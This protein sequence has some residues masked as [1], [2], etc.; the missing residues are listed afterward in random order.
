MTQHGARP[1]CVPRIG[2]PASI[3]HRA[4]D[5][6]LYSLNEMGDE[7]DDE[8]FVELDLEKT[9]TWTGNAV[10]IQAGGE[11][12]LPPSCASE[13]PR[14]PIRGGGRL[15]HRVL[16]H[17]PGRSRGRLEHGALPNA[18]NSFLFIRNLALLLT[19]MPLFSHHSSS[20]RCAWPT[21]RAARHR[22]DG[23]VRAALV[24]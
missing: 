6:Q 2:A 8:E 14:N 5:T 17:V 16:A 10:S 20:S 3:D 1:S 13:R 18:L 12:R 24:E 9:L 4:R 23:R 11:F 22:H 15:R 19:L 7:E 21:A